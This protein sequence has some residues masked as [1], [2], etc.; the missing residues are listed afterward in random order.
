V[1]PVANVKEMEMKTKVAKAKPA[2]GKPTNGKATKDIPAN[3][4]A[5][6][7]KWN[8]KHPDK[9]F[10]WV[11]IGADTPTAQQTCRSCKRKFRIGRITRIDEKGAYCGPNCQRSA[12]KAK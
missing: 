9:K 6:M 2:N 3:A 7:T 10:S 8:E 11:V 1:C 12:S 4:I 5:K